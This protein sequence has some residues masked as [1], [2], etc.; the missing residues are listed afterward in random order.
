MDGKKMGNNKPG[1]DDFEGNSEE[2]RNSGKT[3]MEQSGL[4]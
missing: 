3:S 4:S 2:R 1:V